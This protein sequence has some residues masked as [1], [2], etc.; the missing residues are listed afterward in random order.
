MIPARTGLFFLYLCDINSAI[1]KKKKNYEHNTFEMTNI[2]NRLFV[3]KISI[4]QSVYYLLN[5]LS[6]VKII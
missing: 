5:Q 4:Y 1:N 3:F 6:D 2:I